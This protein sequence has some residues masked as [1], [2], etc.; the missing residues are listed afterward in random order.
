MKIPEVTDLQQDGVRQALLGVNAKTAASLG[1]GWWDKRMEVDGVSR[2]TKGRKRLFGAKGQPACYHVMSRTVG[3][4]VFF[5]D[6]EKEALKTLIW[7]LARFCRVRVLTYSVMGNHYHVLL[8]VPDKEKLVEEFTGDDGERRLLT[9]MRCL[10][11]ASAVES[12]AD[13]LK[14]LRAEGRTSDAQAVVDSVIARM[15]DLSR[16]M[17]E[18]K[19]RFTRWYN[20][21][22][23]RRG[24]LWMDRFKSVIVGDGEALRTVAQYIDLNSVRAGIV[25]DPADYRWCG[26]AE[27]LGGSRRAKRGVCRLM[28]CS[29][30]SWERGSKDAVEN[31][32]AAL[33]AV[34]S[35]ERM[36]EGKL[37]DEGA[38]KKAR[39]LTSP[40]E[41]KGEAA[42]LDQRDKSSAAVGNLLLRRVRYFTDG[43]VIGTKAFVQGVFDAN[44]GEFSEKRTH[45]SQPFRDPVD[46]RK[47]GKT[48]LHA[49]RDLRV[50]VYDGR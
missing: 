11:S 18:V 1:A 26:W 36:D 4:D 5:D 15:A 7:K 41:S 16:Y 23:G 29:L 37:Q 40:G 48:G 3:G 27:A 19:E 50:D 28:E 31:Y 30:D 38:G 32:S 43:A 13:E 9:H 12:L 42:S 49:L 45:P 24:T 39:T 20:K 22:R 21:R 8:E 6:V 17:K 33:E 10:Y 46:P 2:G 35:G 44:R 25:N 14:R 47:R 34:L